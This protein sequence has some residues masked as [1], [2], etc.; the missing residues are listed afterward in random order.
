MREIMCKKSK[1]SYIVTVVLLL[2]LL[3]SPLYSSVDALSTPPVSQNQIVLSTNQ[4]KA[5][6]EELITQEQELQTLKVK[7]KVL[8]ANS[9]ERLRI[10]ND[11][12]ERLTATEQ[13]L[14]S[15][16]ESLTIAQSELSVSKASLTI[17]KSQIK[18]LEHQKKVIKRQRNLYMALAGA[19]GIGLIVK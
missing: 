12:Q 6:K 7:L 5:L 17:L 1:K 8:G 13:H 11:L 19:L 2:S 4:W 10:V 14:T 16:N 9:N 3:F 18:E 15:A